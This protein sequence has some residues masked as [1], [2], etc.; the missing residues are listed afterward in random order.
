MLRELVD[1]VY[2]AWDQIKREIRQLDPHL[3]EQWRAGGFLVDEDV[4]SMY[5]SLST[6]I[7]KLGLDESEEEN[8]EGDSDSEV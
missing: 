5:P 3:Y 1:D 6:V 7:E 2:G 8:E 4:M